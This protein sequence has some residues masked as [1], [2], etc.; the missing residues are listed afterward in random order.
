VILASGSPRRLELLERI[1]LVPIVL[2]SG[3]PEAPN[4]G[5]TPRDY[6]RRLA[7]E[8]AEEVAA[9][10]DDELE[11]E[12]GFD[13]LPDWVIAADTVV[14]FDD[15]VLEKPADGAQAYDMLT[16]L[17]GR[18]HTVVTSFCWHGRHDAVTRVRTVQAD[19]CFR[20]LDDDFIRRYIQTREPMDKAGGYGI[21]RVGATL[22]REI[23][24]SY[25]CVVG[26]PVCEVVEELVRLGGLR[27]YPFL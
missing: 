2:R 10:V 17:S 22:V 25:F 12:P 23:R 3:V 9:R 5:E 6:T 7:C 16:R 18:W 27:D 14:V 24:G 21:Q 4:R 13:A 15:E 19:V 1:G 11:P 20:E 8:K 26:L